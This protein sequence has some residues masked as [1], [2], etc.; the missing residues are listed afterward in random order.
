MLKGDRKEFGHGFQEL[1]K[2]MNDSGKG[3][4]F[5]AAEPTGQWPEGWKKTVYAHY[6]N[7][8]RRDRKLYTFDINGAIIPRQ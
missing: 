2:V 1:N 6:D 7:P 5:I 8:S 4:F 3:P